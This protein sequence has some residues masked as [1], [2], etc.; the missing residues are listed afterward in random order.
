MN[1]LVLNCGSSSLKFQV[2]ETSHAQ[3]LADADRRIYGL[4]AEAPEPEDVVRRMLPYVEQQL[5][6]GVRLS[7][8]TRHMVGLFQGRPG[9]K[10]WR[11]HLSENGHRPG[12]GLEVLLDALDQVLAAAAHRRTRPAA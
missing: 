6:R 4:P 9:A 10:R 1:I 3:I 11:R 8:I 7:A 5:V 2:L 12:A